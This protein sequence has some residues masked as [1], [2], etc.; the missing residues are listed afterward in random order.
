MDATK[1]PADR[2]AQDDQALKRDRA[3]LRNRRFSRRKV[4]IT[5][6]GIA[7]AA[8]GGGFMAV[9]AAVPA[10]PPAQPPP[11][12]GKP[13][14]EQPATRAPGFD[15]SLVSAIS[16]L[17]RPTNATDALPSEQ[18]K[19][20]QDASSFTGANTS[21]T[22]RAVVWG[23]DAAY[24]APSH[25]GLC[26]VW[27]RGG[28]ACADRQYAGAGYLV[29]SDSN[30]G[31]SVPTGDIRITGVVPDDASKLAWVA[32]DGSVHSL[33]PDGNTYV[34]LAVPSDPSRLPTTIQWTSG[35]VDRALQAPLDDPPEAETCAPSSK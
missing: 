23:A 22:R 12:D 6:V 2:P 18:A 32:K 27:A 26:I 7:V 16:A 3:R 28:G 9:S 35:G 11:V 30:C 19:E 1:P 21:V 29:F 5:G 34:I 8:G 14:P 4:A 24:F 10:S 15:Q 33:T 31:V 17:R 20:F 13:T 25:Q